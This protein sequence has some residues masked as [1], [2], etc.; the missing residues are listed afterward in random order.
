MNEIELEFVLDNL[1]R[2]YNGNVTHATNEQ[3]VKSLL[4]YIYFD[5]E[6]VYAIIDGKVNT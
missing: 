4:F 3:T 6:Y 5:Y 2:K 1:T